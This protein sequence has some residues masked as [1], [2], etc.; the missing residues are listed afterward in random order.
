MASVSFISMEAPGGQKL[1]VPKEGTVNISI[2]LT[3]K[4]EFR[5]FKKFSKVLQKLVMQQGMKSMDLC[6]GYMPML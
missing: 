1:L 4:F 3:R 2:L 5:E 6:P